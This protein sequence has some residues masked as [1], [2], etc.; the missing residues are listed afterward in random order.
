MRRTANLIPSICLTFLGV[1]QVWAQYPTGYTLEQS[2]TGF[3]ALSTEQ[4]LSRFTSVKMGTVV[5]TDKAAIVFKGGPQLNSLNSFSY[6][7]YTVGPGLEGQLT[8]WAAIYL[9]TQANKTYDDWMADYIGGSPNV[10]Y[11][12]AEPYY[13]TGNPVLN[14]WQLQDAY[15]AGALTW[16][17]LESPDYPHSAP[18]LSAYISGAAMSWP[19]PG[20]GNQAFATREYGSLYISSIKIRMGY[21]GPWV[22][23]LAYVDDVTLAGYLEGFDPAQVPGLSMPGVIVLLTLTALLSVYVLTR[24]AG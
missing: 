3:A 1:A 19:V 9:H 5:G 7:T 12:Q 8:A 20:H 4:Y 16:V 18:P 17:G 2:G 11:I 10:F 6:W 15:G 24:K 22:N 14:T 23:T 13:A 21:G